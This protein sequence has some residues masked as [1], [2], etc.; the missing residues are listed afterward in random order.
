MGFVSLTRFQHGGERQVP[1]ALRAETAAAARAGTTPW[2]TEWAQSDDDTGCDAS[3]EHNSGGRG[4]Y[5]NTYPYPKPHPN[6]NPNPNTNRNPN[7]NPNP[8]TNTNPYPTRHPPDDT[9]DE[10]IGAGSGSKDR[11]DDG[12][13]AAPGGSNSDDD[14]HAAPRTR[15]AATSVQRR[16]RVISCRW[17]KHVS[18][19]NRVEGF[20]EGIDAVDGTT[21]ATACDNQDYATLLAAGG[22]AAQFEVLYEEMHDDE[23]DRAEPS[24]AGCVDGDGDDG[25]GDSTRPQRTPTQPGD[26]GNGGS[27][28]ATGRE[29]APHPRSEPMSGPK[30]KVTAEEGGSTARKRRLFGGGSR[31]QGAGSS[32]D[33]SA[34]RQRGDSG[35]A[36]SSSSAITAQGRDL[37]RMESGHDNGRRDKDGGRG[38][39]PGS[40]TRSKEDKEAQRRAQRPTSQTGKRRESGDHR[41]TRKRQTSTWLG[42]KGSAG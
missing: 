37:W 11:E 21:G 8:N 16:A 22:D 26:S 14:D 28:E 5:P 1:E 42:G 23:C 7:P 17:R 31:E 33:E 30:R 25:Y 4:D 38:G 9:G 40:S 3:D 12:E 13:H 20:G 32:D 10:D 27:G 34:Q 41:H 29:T 18:R 6:H 35:E 24:Q 39:T 36:A 19:H 15:P 2:A